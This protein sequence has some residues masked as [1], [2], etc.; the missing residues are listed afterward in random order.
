MDESLWLTEE[1]LAEFTGYRWRAKQQQALAE[2]GVAF[3]VNP[4]G[5]IL[6]RHDAV[7]GGKPVRS[8]KV[9]PNWGAIHKGAA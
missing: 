2:M 4:R 9:E 5:R 7:G 3:A 1:Q 6:V 8:K